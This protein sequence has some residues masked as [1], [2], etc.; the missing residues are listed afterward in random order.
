MKHMTRLVLILLAIALMSRSFAQKPVV[1]TG[2]EEGWSKIG[3]MTANFEKQ[4]E[5]IVVLGKDQFAA[6]KIKVVDAPIRIEN[7][8]VFFEGGEVQDISLNKV[9][10]AGSDSRVIDLKANKKELAKVQFTYKTLS[11][12]NDKKADVE[13]YGYKTHRDTSAESYQSD[14]AKEKMREDGKEIRDAVSETVGKAKA[15]IVDQRFDGK[16]GPAGQTVY[17][18]NNSR[19]YFVGE[20]GD[21]IYLRADQLKDNP[22]KD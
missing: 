22:D 10:A 6:I 9:M 13:L 17:I 14:E 12:K 2:T 7:I 15:A 21:K 20:N 4:T 8:Q 3:Q 1:L 19:Y 18:D 11:N 5:S 16:V